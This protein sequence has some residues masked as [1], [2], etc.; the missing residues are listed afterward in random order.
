[1]A[2][3]T[4]KHLLLHIFCFMNLQ[5]LPDYTAFDTSVQLVVL[6]CVAVQVEAPVFLP[7]LAPQLAPGSLVEVHGLEKAPQCAARAC[8]YQKSASGVNAR[9]QRVQLYTIMANTCK[10]VAYLVRCNSPSKSRP[11]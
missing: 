2:Y 9:V 10:H 3:P 5:S 1:M 11:R 4:F 8:R 7:A 6:Q